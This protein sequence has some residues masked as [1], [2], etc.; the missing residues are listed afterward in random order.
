[1]ERIEG[2]KSRCGLGG[3]Q[4]GLG[5]GKRKDQYGTVGFILIFSKSSNFTTPFDFKYQS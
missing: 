1:L 3:K 2:K 4:L 5:K